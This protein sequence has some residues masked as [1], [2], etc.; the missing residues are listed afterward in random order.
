MTFQSGDFKSPASAIPPPGRVHSTAPARRKLPA[1]SSQTV[2]RAG[3]GGGGAA[4]PPRRIRSFIRFLELN[5]ILYGGDEGVVRARK[6][7]GYWLK[8]FP[9]SSALRGDFM[10]AAGLNEAKALLLQ[11]MEKRDS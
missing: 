10:K 9:N 6:L 2:H 7:V 1:H 3:C 4:G 11:Y 8:G 5:T